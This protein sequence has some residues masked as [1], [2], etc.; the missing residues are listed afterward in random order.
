MIED[1]D[2]IIVDLAG[3]NN[4]ASKAVARELQR[5]NDET[6][7]TKKE[8]IEN[9]CSRA[10]KT[11]TPEWATADQQRLKQDINQNQ[12]DRYGGTKIRFM[13]IDDRQAVVHKNTQNFWFDEC[14][15]NCYRSV[16]CGSEEQHAV[17]TFDRYDI[18]CIQQC[19]SVSELQN[20][21]RSLSQKRNP[22]R[23]LIKAAT[24]RLETIQLHARMESPWN[25]SYDSIPTNEH[26]MFLQLH[27][28][29]SKQ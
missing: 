8:A 16:S 15:P 19:E 6:E 12:N 25:R 2:K 20:T 28:H 23:H 13:T 21:V 3:I 4:K 17:P 26:E 27:S 7:T 11:W 5:L 22:P 14:D 24:R 18:R 10:L 9:S 1:I 29:K